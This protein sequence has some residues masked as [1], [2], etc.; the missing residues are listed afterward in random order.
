MTIEQTAPSADETTLRNQDLKTLTAMLQ[1]Q[2]VQ[3]ADFVAPAATIRAEEGVIVVKGV[4]AKL[5]EDGVTQI[6][7]E[8]RPTHTFLSGLA[9]KL[10]VP[11]GYL[12]RMHRTRPD[13]FDANVNGWLH[14][15]KA[16]VR[17]RDGRAEL[18]REAVPGDDRSF[19]MRTFRGEEG[20]GLGRA[21]LSDKY[22]RFD[23]LDA[24]F[25]TLDGIKEAGVPIEVRGCDLTES[26]MYVRIQAEGIQAYA[27]QLLKDYRSPFTGKTGDENPTVFA[28]ILVSNSEVGA[29]ASTI[30]PQL[31]VQVCDN[32]MTINMDVVK[33]IHL[34]SRMAEGVIDW[35]DEAREKEIELMRIKARD[36]VRTFLNVDYV[37]RTIARLEVTAGAPVSGADKVVR[38][39]GKKLAFSEE[40]IEGILDHF[41]KG[42][43]T[44]AGGVMQAVTSYAQTITNADVA[45]EVESQGVEAMQLAA[46]A[47]K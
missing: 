2:Q 10:D 24:L 3:K 19:F 26:R 23:N 15:R 33:A 41:I 22:K 21:L 30:T 42:G 43:Q 20:P 4:E 13:L 16:K 39:V 18:I 37:N 1:R 5:S 17:Q 40:Q 12:K 32:G 25:A 44:T 31:V 14:G 45:A 35:S 38:A 46:A 34:G 9:S 28:G 11:V 27:P 8:Y 47:A 6:D 7:G 29:G 36:A